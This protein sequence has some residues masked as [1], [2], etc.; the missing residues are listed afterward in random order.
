MYESLVVV[1]FID[2]ISGA[3]GMDRL[4]PEDPYEAARCRRWCD[5]VNRDCCSPYYG[6][7]VPRDEAQRQVHF[8]ELLQGIRDFANEVSKTPGP[9]FLANMQLSNVDI[10]LFPWAF[11]YYVL[12]HYRNYVIPDTPDYQ[13]FHEWYQAMLTLPSVQRTLP[14]REKY[15][16]HIANYANGTARSK[17]ANAVRR[18]A[19]AHEL[20]D[21]K[22]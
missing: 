4:V 22:D 15:L 11:R 20:D 2:Q 17:V 9:L 16:E 1:D 14:D 7:L 10:A 8:E 6:V 5:K 21:R 18:G 3:T 13:A 19:A 12:E